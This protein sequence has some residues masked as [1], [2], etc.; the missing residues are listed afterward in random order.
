MLSRLI[1]WSLRNVVLVLLLTV[2]II[3]AGIYALLKTPLDALPDLSDVQ[4]IVYTEYSGQGPQVVE[5]QVTYP[6][7]TAMLAVPRSK[8]VRGFSFFGA[9]FVYVIFEDGTDIY[10]ARSRVLEY[11]NTAAERLPQGVTP[12]L[13]PDATGVGWVYQYALTSDRHDLGELRAMQDWFVRYQLTKARGVAEVASVGG[14]VKQYQVTVDPHKLHAYGIDLE[15]VMRAIRENNRDVGGRV[16]EMA[17]REYMVRGRGYLRG[18]DDLERIVLDVRG[19]HAGAAARRRAHRDRAGRAARHHGAERGG[20]GGR[21]HRDGALR[22]QCARRHPLPERAHCRDRLGSSG[23]CSAADS[24]RPLRADP[25]RDSNAAQD[26]DRGEPHRRARLRPVSSARAQCT[27]GNRDAACRCADGLHRD[28]RAGHELQHH[29][30]RRHRDRDRRDGRRGDRDDRERAQAHRARR[31][32]PLAAAVDDRRVPRGRACPVLQPADHHG[33][34]PSRLRARGAGRTAVPPACLDQDLRD[35][36][37]GA[38]VGH[39]GARADAALHPR[40][41][42]AGAQ[43]PGEPD[44]DRTL[45]PGDPA[46]AAPQGGHAGA[47]RGRARADRRAGEPHRERVHADAQRGHAAVHAGDAARPVGYQGR[48]AAPAA[49]PHH[50]ELPGGGIGIRQGRA[51]PHRHGS[52]ADGDVRDGDQSRTREPSGAPA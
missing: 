28:A 11:L 17:E 20:G 47:G 1:A 40:Q 36:G 30:P 7:T 13:G 49:G 5:D 37:G 42:P 41:D 4:V 14:F 35:G 8:V 22:R 23:R 32:Q 52:R 51:R 27:G 24:L 9:S 45:S 16:V 6:L 46:R 31:R 50:Q 29:E 19:G 43:Q 18:T 48:R 44:A 12:T 38:A 2:G 10:W 33:V 34:L 25:P 3:A 26:A 39:P 15:T 21:R